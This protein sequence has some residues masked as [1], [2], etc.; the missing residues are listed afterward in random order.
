MRELVEK[1]QH[2]E[3]IGLEAGPFAHLLALG[4][5]NL[6]HGR[7]PGVEMERS[8]AVVAREE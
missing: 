1:R 4:E 5:V 6:G 8:E 2:H 7:I 3:G